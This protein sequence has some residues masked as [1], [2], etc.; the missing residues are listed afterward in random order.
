MS[1]LFLSRARLR[2]DA[3]VT[4]LARLLVP[5]DPARR[6]DASHRLVWSL[7]ADSPD[8]KRDFLW[9]EEAPGRFMALSS[10]PPADPHGLFDVEFKRFEAVL[11]V[12]DRIG[13]TLRA[14][15]VVSRGEVK[16]QRGKRHDV[17][18]D[19]LRDVAP[20][21]RASRRP[22]VIISAGR[23]WFARQGEGNG[24]VPTGEAA[25]DGYDQ[26]R[27]PRAAGK[28]VVFSVLDLGGVLEVTD[29]PRFLA[30]VAA[31]FGAAR[32]YGCGLMLIRRVRR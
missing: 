6:T 31:G 14:N 12:G 28:P 7:F 15:P 11:R 21:E 13:F 2:R 29:P 17:V 16:D 5:P 25:I 1:E 23:S 10:R 24:F 8:R 19:A 30:R 4:A 22:E 20:A 3:P 18:M 26:I 9:R 27:I 32:A